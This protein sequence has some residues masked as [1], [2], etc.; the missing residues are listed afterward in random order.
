MGGTTFLNLKKMSRNFS[1]WYEVKN[2]NIFRKDN[3]LVNVGVNTQGGAGE[4]KNITSLTIN[5]KKSSYPLFPEAEDKKLLNITNEQSVIHIK[6][7]FLRGPN[8]EY[9][10]QGWIV[11]EEDYLSQSDL[12]GDVPV[13]KS[14]LTKNL[15]DGVVTGSSLKKLTV[16]VEVDSFKD[17]VNVAFNVLRKENRNLMVKDIY[18]KKRFA[19]STGFLKKFLNVDNDGKHLYNGTLNDLFEDYMIRQTVE[20]LDLSEDPWKIQIEL[21]RALLEKKKLSLPV[22]AIDLAPFFIYSF[23]EDPISKKFVAEVYGSGDGDLGTRPF[24]Q[25]SEFDDNCD[26][27]VA[28]ERAVGIVKVTEIY[29]Q[30]VADKA[31]SEISYIEDRILPEMR[32]K[33]ADDK[34]VIVK[35][36]TLDPKKCTLINSK[37]YRQL[38]KEYQGQGLILSY[39]NTN[40]YG[41]SPLI[42]PG[43]SVI[44]HQRTEHRFNFLAKYNVALINFNI[45]HAL[46]NKWLEFKFWETYCQGFMPKV[47]LLSHLISK[48]SDPYNVTP[49]EFVKVANAEFPNGF[50]AKNIWDYNGDESIIYH[51]RDIVGLTEKYRASGFREYVDK[52]K[53]SLLGCEPIEDLNE[54]IKKM[55]H[56]LGWKIERLLNNSHET[57][58]QEFKQIYRE[59]RVECNGGICPEEL[60]N[61]D[62]VRCAKDKSKEI[63]RVGKVILT[64]FRKCHDKVPENLRGMPLTSD[65]ALLKDQTV[66]CFETN[67]G[68]NSWLLHNTDLLNA[69]NKFLKKY[70]QF[71]KKNKK[72]QDGMTPV[73]QM[74]YLKDMLKTWGV[75][76]KTESERFGWLRDRITD[77]DHVLPH[78]L[79]LPKMN[80]IE[81]NPKTRKTKFVLVTRLVDSSFEVALKYINKQ[82]DSENRFLELFLHLISLKPLMPERGKEMVETMKKAFIKKEKDNLLEDKE[83]LLKNY[84]NVYFESRIKKVASKFKK[85]VSLFYVILLFDLPA[86]DLYEAV[87]IYQNW[88]LKKDLTLSSLSTLLFQ[89]D[90]TDFSKFDKL[91]TEKFPIASLGQFKKWST[92]FS[93]ALK[94]LYKLK[95][96]NLNLAPK[97]NVVDLLKE[98]IPKLRTAITLFSEDEK[99]DSSV[100]RL[101][102][103]NVLDVI[104]IVSDYGLFKLSNSVYDVEFK[105]LNNVLEKADTILT[106][107][108][109]PR[110]IYALSLMHTE[111][112]K[113]NESERVKALKIKFLEA[114]NDKGYWGETKKLATTFN[115]LLAFLNFNGL[116]FVKSEHFGELANRHEWRENLKNRGAFQKDPTYKQ[117]SYFKLLKAPLDLL[118]YVKQGAVSN[119]IKFLESSFEKFDKNDHLDDRLN[120][121][122][123]VTNVIYMGPSLTEEQRGI[124]AGIYE[125]F[126]NGK[127]KLIK[128]IME[129][130]EPYIQKFEDESK[131]YSKADIL[132][133]GV[134]LVGKMEDIID[135]RNLN[136][137]DELEKI[138]RKLNAFWIKQVEAHKITKE[139]LGKTLFKNFDMYD[140]N[141]FEGIVK[142]MQYEFAYK[143]FIKFENKFVDVM[144]ALHG[145]HRLQFKIPGFSYSKFMKDWIERVRK[146]YRPVQSN[147]KIAVKGSVQAKAYKSLLYLVTHVLYS[148]NDFSL[149]KIPKKHY[150]PEFDFLKQ[151]L[152]DT[153]YIVK[154]NDILGELVDCLRLFSGEELDDFTQELI[155]RAQVFIVNRQK[156]GGGFPE[157]GVNSDIHATHT[158]LTALVNHEYA[159]HE[160][161]DQLNDFGKPLSFASYKKKLNKS[162]LLLLPHERK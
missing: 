65:V 156:A 162:G 29:G 82:M 113:F 55:K 86:N 45:A 87:T 54:Q 20:I 77:V 148:I 124:L 21:A 132:D 25:F 23:P 157:G 151:A 78:E 17:V 60:V 150:I 123:A 10:K 110:V 37:D 158:A 161:D 101:I 149:Y 89:V 97:F 94:F 147:P 135:L 111:G 160:N 102:I 79:D 42:I 72:L 11:K 68:G 12:E 34:P 96:L 56:F 30:I 73:E 27:Q 141:V 57:M 85:L 35:Y 126:K 74:N 118:P 93:D 67:P 103:D 146:V 6:T 143:Q 88:F 122:H 51:K 98:W 108:Q 47:V 43:E 33:L 95:R 59:F 90:T 84:R 2:S 18:A 159:N 69:H 138:V 39:I 116:N 53:Q 8:G 145:A 153:I 70:P 28:I 121:V 63:D 83:R 154:N 128:P 46:E 81:K 1:V 130:F 44:Y 99:L 119:G 41:I 120:Y 64:D 71:Y 125:K 13:L 112:D 52:V 24:I 155:T 117:L 50:V 115:T 9:L 129:K 136:L 40:E 127:E 80:S 58:L 31:L 100:R 152:S 62:E 76:V 5:L 15:K 104:D 19:G 140:F 16:N 75:D 139:E 133:L 106:N 142:N 38:E 134:F 7:P 49:E 26:V 92:Q 61:F 144:G 22:R 36:I 4:T 48:T 109:L 91:V 137:C 114:Q 14:W 3:Q 131:E 32:E 66:S 107:V 105:F